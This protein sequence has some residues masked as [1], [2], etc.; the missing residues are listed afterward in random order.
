MD[1][2]PLLQLVCSHFFGPANGLVDMLVHHVPS[3]LKNAAAKVCHIYTGDMS[4]PQAIAMKACDV[5]G[6]L[7]IHVVKLYNSDD[8]TKFSAF[9]RIFSGTVKQGQIVRVLGENYTPD[10]EEDSS[11]QGVEGL[12]IY[13][14]RYVCVCFG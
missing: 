1:V 14:S 3:P 11:M 5:N 13:E 8:M 9:G 10:D 7:M 4:S 6:P 2:K 12:H